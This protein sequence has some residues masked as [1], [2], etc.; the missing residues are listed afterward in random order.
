[1]QKQ[2]L[3]RFAHRICALAFWPAVALIV[4]GE[5]VPKLPQTFDNIADKWQ[6]FTAYLGLGAM[7]VVALGLRPRLFWALLGIVALGGVLEILQGFTG[8]DPELGDFIANTVG[9]AAGAL[10]GWTFLLAMRPAKLVG[11]GRDD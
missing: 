10:A 11:P 5:L 3:L 6:H 7:A 9:T 2:S 8:R 4:W 1:M